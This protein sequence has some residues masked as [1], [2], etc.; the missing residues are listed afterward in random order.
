MNIFHLINDFPFF[1]GIYFRFVDI[2]NI[3]LSL[4]VPP[5]RRD[6]ASFVYYYFKT[7]ARPGMSYADIIDYSEPLKI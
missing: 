4:K 3:P 5:T 6:D 2:K 7:R 1:L